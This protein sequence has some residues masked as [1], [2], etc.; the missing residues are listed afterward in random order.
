MASTPSTTTRQALASTEAPADVTAIVRRIQ[1]GLP[2]AEFD[3][4][5]KATGLSAARLAELVAIPDTTMRRRRQSGRLSP[6]ESDR[7]Y[8]VRRICDQAAALFE[9]DWAATRAWLAAPQPGLRGQRPVD[10]LATEVGAR[11]VERLIGRL[12]HG[13]AL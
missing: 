12:E 6:E 4:L 5:V 1:A 2:V 10:W 11:E 9:G 3:R 13:V 7:L 8:R